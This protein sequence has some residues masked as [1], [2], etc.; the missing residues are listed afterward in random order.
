MANCSRSGSRSPRPRSGRSCAR[1]GSTRHPTTT[2]TDFLRSQVHALLAADF[3]ETVTLPGA[4][5]YILNVTEHP[6]AQIYIRRLYR[7]SSA[8]SVAGTT[9]PFKLDTSPD[10]R[11]PDRTKLRTQLGISAPHRSFVG[12]RWLGSPS[13]A[14]PQLLTMLPA[15][16]TGQSEYVIS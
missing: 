7:D 6:T 4:R 10:L 3:I 8:D 14:L 15:Q 1:P 16:L 12:R 2:W 5:L 11:A 13:A 9:P